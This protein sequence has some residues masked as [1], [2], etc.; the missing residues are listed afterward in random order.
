MFLDDKLVV[1]NIMLISELWALVNN[2][3]I[4]PGGEMEWTPV[5][6]CQKTLEINSVGP[7]R[8]TKA[9]LPLLRRSR[10]RVVVV[11][12]FLGKKIL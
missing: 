8:I 4:A 12:S 5:E 7:Y 10:G 11:V 9:F 3:G 6:V 2:A 1:T